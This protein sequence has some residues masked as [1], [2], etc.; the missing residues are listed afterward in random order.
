MT[1]TKYVTIILQFQSSKT[2][3]KQIV[4]PKV[5]T[6]NDRIIQNASE[7]QHLVHQDCPPCCELIQTYCNV[8]PITLYKLA[9]KQHYRNV[10]S[11]YWN[12]FVEILFVYTKTKI[13]L[14]KKYHK[15]VL[16]S[17]HNVLL[18][19][20]LFIDKSLETLSVANTGT[21]VSALFTLRNTGNSKL[22]KSLAYFS[23]HFKFC[24]STM[25]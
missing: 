14:V 7:N 13:L 9:S 23:L 2:T 3:L 6:W 21:N 17:N 20:V 25:K 12:R 8:V 11:S 18:C 5:K 4:I 24:S 1:R 19:W 10:I 16:H 15:L 22:S